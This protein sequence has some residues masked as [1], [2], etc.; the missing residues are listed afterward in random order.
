MKA[1]I[2]VSNKTYWTML[3]IGCVLVI[4]SIVYALVAGNVKALGY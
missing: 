2:T 4:G 3:I 1:E